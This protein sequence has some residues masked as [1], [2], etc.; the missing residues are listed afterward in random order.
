MNMPCSDRIG[1]LEIGTH[2]T[3]SDGALEKAA[4]MSADLPNTALC[5]AGIGCTSHIQCPGIDGDA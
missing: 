5:T 1:A 4:L 3:V 2:H